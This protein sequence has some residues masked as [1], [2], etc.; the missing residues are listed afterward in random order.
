M[1]PSGTYYLV[2]LVDSNNNLLFEQKWS[3]T[4]KFVIDGVW[5]GLVTGL[6]F[7]WLWPAGA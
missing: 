6:T 5:Y 2:R 4:G 1:V 7:G 3:I